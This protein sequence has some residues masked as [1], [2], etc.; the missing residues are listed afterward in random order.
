MAKGTGVEK[1]P[2]IDYNCEIAVKAII[3]MFSEDLVEWY[4]KKTGSSKASSS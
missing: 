4:E 2:L 3:R 1:K